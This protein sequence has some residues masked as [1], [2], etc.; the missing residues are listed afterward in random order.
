M[1][2]IHTEMLHYENPKNEK[3]IDGFKTKIQRKLRTDKLN[4]RK[5]LILYLLTTKRPSY[6]FSIYGKQLELEGNYVV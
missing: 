3:Q 5:S 4:K 6:I 2:I 1:V